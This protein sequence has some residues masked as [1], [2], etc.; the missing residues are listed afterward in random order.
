[1]ALHLI[2]I[3]HHA[4]NKASRIR[5]DNVFL[6]GPTGCG[7]TETFRVLQQLEDQF[8]IPVIMKNSL[9]YSPSK[10]W[11]GDPLDDIFQDL[12]L[13]ALQIFKRRHCGRGPACESEEQAVSEMASNGIVLIDEF[14]KLQIV[15]S[16]EDKYCQEYQ[17]RL[18]KL[19][20]GCEFSVSL[21]EKTEEGKT[22]EVMYRLDTSGTMFVFLGAFEG[23]EEITRERLLMEQEAHTVQG[24]DSSP[25]KRI[26]FM[27]DVQAAA[28]VP[29][30]ET[31]LGECDLTPSLEDL[32]KYGIKRELAGR[33]PVRAVY[34]SLSISDM[35]K[36]MQE[37][38]T[39]A[40]LEYQERFQ[41]IGHSLYCDEDALQEIARISVERKAGA[42]GLSDIFF[43]LLDETIYQLTGTLE[44]V[45]CILRGSDIRQ[46]QAP[47]L[48]DMPQDDLEDFE[49]EYADDVQWYIDAE[50]SVYYRTY[51]RSGWAPHKN[52]WA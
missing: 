22:R 5:K 37:S 9:D 26:G 12:V 19:V 51:R 38:K 52:G 42:R 14:D 16:R 40:Y 41:V 2:R 44:P 25:C 15:D 23:L 31:L 34:R 6:I 48:V 8:E 21:T 46:R 7:K 11:Q 35:V 1:V 13:E 4:Y 3:W 30:E 43:E 33:F 39:S 10:S 20:E 36:I 47:L 28:P 27:A 45:Q 29:T 18:L 17:S 49:P 32:I 24:A 50:K